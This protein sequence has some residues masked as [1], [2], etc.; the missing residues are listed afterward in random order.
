[1]VKSLKQKTQKEF[2]RLLISSI[3]ISLLIACTGLFIYCYPNITNKVLGIITGIVFLINGL[4]I[5]IK[6]FKRDGAKLYAYNLIFGIVLTILGIVIMLVPSSV[7]TFI[8][9]CLGIY[10]ITIGANK[11]TYG[12]WFKIGN[13]K[14]WLLTVTIGIMLILFGFLVIANPFSA[15]T[16]TKLV[17]IFLIISS[18]LDITDTIMLK[19]RADKITQIFW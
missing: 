3:I 17:G 9:V 12:I 2:N 13:D 15:L 18:I 1:M 8:T 6:Y 14:S 10:L 11:I 5:I 7:A 4:N 19:R 16:L